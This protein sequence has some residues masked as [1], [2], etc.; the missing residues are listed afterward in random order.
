MARNALRKK[1]EIICL[2]DSPLASFDHCN[3]RTG[4]EVDR[5]KPSRLRSKKNHEDKIQLRR[6]KRKKVVRAKARASKLPCIPQRVLRVLKILR[7]EKF[8]DLVDKYFKPFETA[9]KSQTDVRLPTNENS[10][11]TD[12]EAK[13]KR[14]TQ[15]SNRLIE[16]TRAARRIQSCPTN[17]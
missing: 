15:S 9:Q 3:R 4:F 5:R 13:N 16:R 10:A 14:E 6:T 2:Q 11:V 12:G 7:H 8:L 17:S 1:G